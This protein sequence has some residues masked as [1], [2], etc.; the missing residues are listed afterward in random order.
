MAKK[1]SNEGICTN[2]I[3]PGLIETD[4]T[5]DE[6]SSINLEELESQI[7]LRRLGDPSDVASLAFFLAE[8]GNYIT[9]QTLNINGGIYFS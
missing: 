9:G 6:L 3:A 4:M 2:A 7:P 8:D 5:K 1:F